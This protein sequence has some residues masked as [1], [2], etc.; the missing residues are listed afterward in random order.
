MTIAG[1]SV[2]WS[3]ASAAGRGWQGNRWR[4]RGLFGIQPTMAGHYE[5]FIQQPRSIRDHIF[6]EIPRLLLY[7]RR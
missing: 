1:I 5:N 6:H 7:W 2:L 3:A 4:G